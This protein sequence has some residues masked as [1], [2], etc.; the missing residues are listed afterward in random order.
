MMSFRISQNCLF[1]LPLPVLLAA[2]WFFPLFL[3][4]AKAADTFNLTGAM[5]TPRRGH[6]AVRLADAR[7]VVAGGLN[8]NGTLGSAEIYDPATGASRRL[9]P[10]HAVP[11]AGA[12]SL[13]YQVRTFTRDG[14]SYAAFLAHNELGTPD[15]AVFY[16]IAPLSAVAVTETLATWQAFHFGQENLIPANEAGLWGADADPDGDGQSNLLEYA[17]H[18]DPLT[19]GMP[20]TVPAR[21]NGRLTLTF[22]RDSLRADLRLTVEAADALD[23]AVWTPLAISETGGVFAAVSPA[24]P[25]ISEA[26]ENSLQ[27]VTV[28]DIVSSASQPRRFLRLRASLLP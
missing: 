25:L 6:T 20:A 23:Q 17:L 13:D 1:S 15:T 27:R 10:D 12:G 22:P 8:Q 3:P 24:S 4:A 26:V 9:I 16:G 11:P 28:R 7:V 14:E 21:S 18:S 2:L 5:S 19:P